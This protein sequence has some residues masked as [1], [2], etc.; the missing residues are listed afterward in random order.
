MGLFDFFKKKKAEEQA[1][2]PETAAAEREELNAGLEKTKQGLFS[3]LARAVAGRSKV[4]DDML[5]EL[6]E[7]L[8]TSD[9]GVETTVKI[10]R[11][12]EERVARDKY[13]NAAEL[14]SILRD[15][16]ALLLEEN[17]GNDATFGLDAKEGEP[18]V[19]MVVGVN[20]AGKTTTIGKLAAQLRKAGKKVYIGAADTFRAAAIDQLG[21][22]AERAG[23]TMI[24][25]EMGSDP[26][27]VAFDTLKSAKA[28]G[29]DV[30]LIDTAGRLHNKIG[31]MNELTKIRNVMAKVIPDAPHEV[32]L[33]LDG[34]TGQ[35]AF[36]QARQFTQATK[37]TSL[38]IT[39]L[40]GTAKGG[41][42]IGI[43]DQFHV[44]VRYIGIGEGIDQLKIFDRRE[45]VDALFGDK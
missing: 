41:V 18:Y 12:I 21:V 10:I 1:A 35:N 43:S 25:Q 29:A 8:I 28:N 32:M 22:W 34:S 17:H 4:D 39:K 26:A 13:M 9:V 30:V 37:V 40:D 36:E 11:R 23:A 24:R 19:V 2:A 33:V 15:E 27:S 16:I 14:Q 6:E 5:D 44:P 3:K 20:G 7:I 31:L 45:F 42:V 38:A